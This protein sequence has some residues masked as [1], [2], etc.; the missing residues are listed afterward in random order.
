METSLPTL[1]RD[2][3]GATFEQLDRDLNYVI[4]KALFHGEVIL[5]S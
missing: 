4:L 2:D 5:C 3:K 1:C